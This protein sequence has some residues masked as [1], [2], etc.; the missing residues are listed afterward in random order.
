[1]TTNPAEYLAS[2]GFDALVGERSL[3][4]DEDDPESVERARL[5]DHARVRKTLLEA[6]ATALTNSDG[7][8]WLRR[9]ITWPDRVPGL[10]TWAGQM[11]LAKIIAKQ[12][13]LLSSAQGADLFE[14]R[15]AARGSTGIDPLGCVD[16]IDAGF[17][18]DAQGMAIEQRPGLELL[19]ILGLELVPLVSFGSRECGFVHG[20]QLWRFDV[21]P[22]S[23]EY[24]RRW[25]NL[26]RVERV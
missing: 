12:R 10:R 4:R 19:A 5:R 1:V 15:A 3:P 2:V 13:T 26:R 17:S 8:S 18:L 25:D 6:T 20:G 16:A 24:Y 7:A 14:A 11:T 22:R 23:G 21:L 9:R